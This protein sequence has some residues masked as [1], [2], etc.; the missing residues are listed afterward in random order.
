MCQKGGT[1][2]NAA[3]V[4]LCLTV[5][6]FQALSQV[7]SGVEYLGNMNLYPETGYNDCWGYVAPDGREYALLGVR[8]GTSI[9][10]IT[11]APDLREVTFI[12]NP[13]RTSSWKDIKTY[14]NYAYVVTEDTGG[15]QIIDLSALPDTAV[16]AVTYKGFQRSHN[17][18]IDT[19]AALL[20]AEGDDPL[21]VV[22]LISLADPLQPTEVSV[23]GAECHDIYARNG[24]AY[25]SEGTKASFAVYDVTN[26]AL[27][28]LLKRHFI[29]AGGYMHNAWLSDDGNYLMTTEE[30][31]GKDVKLWNISDLD[32]IEMTDSYLASGGLAHNTHLHGNYAYISHYVDGLRIVDISNP[33][34]IVEVA[35]YDTYPLAGT[36]FA[37]A[38]GAFPFFP[39]Q[40]VLIS[41]MQT[42]LYVVRFPDV[43][44]SVGGSFSVPVTPYLSQNFPNPFNAST[45]FKFRTEERTEVKLKIFNMLGR[46]I[47]VLIDGVRPPGL[48]SYHWNAGELPSGVYFYQLSV[49]GK[50][51]QTRKMILTK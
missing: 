21:A 27:P 41:D 35:H 44:V 32:S 16:L 39:S 31:Q 46:E 37:G 48:H 24:R 11:D 15:M 4:A 26:P 22:R 19:A 10:D 25:I 33:N 40:K 9:V 17:L 2:L 18:Y 38:W 47:A 36:G 28:V 49:G 23:F 8:S 42:G 3:S 50:V 51:L 1:P 7:S 14:R 34:S 45:S 6:S 12:P 13:G 29:P 30:S 5:V 43:S 20:Y